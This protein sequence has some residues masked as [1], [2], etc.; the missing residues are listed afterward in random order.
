MLDR[1][2][3]IVKL[4]V[5][6]L[7]FIYLTQEIVFNYHAYPTLIAGFHLLEQLYEG[8]LDVSLLH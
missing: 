6:L 8:G 1:V 2:T 7:A 5:L 3:A 4:A